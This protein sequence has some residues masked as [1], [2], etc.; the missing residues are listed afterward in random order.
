MSGT[1]ITTVEASPEVLA[2]WAEEFSKPPEIENDPN[3][4]SAAEL[5]EIAGVEH[6]T[7]RK[8]LHEGVKAGKYVVKNGHRVNIAGRKQAMPLYQIVKQK[9]EPKKT[10][11]RKK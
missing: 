10:P 3:W 5:A 6:R 2:A 1:T 11:K 8:W 4:L 9:S 7:M